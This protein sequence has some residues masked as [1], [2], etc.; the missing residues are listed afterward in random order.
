[1][2]DPGRAAWGDWQDSSWQDPSWS[3]SWSSPWGWNWG[4]SSGWA[5]DGWRGR[6]EPTWSTWGWTSEEPRWSN[7]DWQASQE[8]SWSTRD[9]QRP[10]EAS[11]STWDWK[12][13]PAE[14]PKS[15]WDWNAETEDPVR[16][17]RREQAEEPVPE[18][19]PAPLPAPSPATAYREEPEVYDMR[20]SASRELE[21]QPDVQG[22]EVGEAVQDPWLHY[23]EEK[24]TP[25]ARPPEVR[26]AP[27]PAP[28]RQIPRRPRDLSAKIF[29]SG[30][31]LDTLPQTLG[32]YCQTVGEVRYA[33]VYMDP[34]NGS[35]NGT[36][37]VDFDCE[38]T[39]RRA[40]RDL[41][42]TTLDGCQITVRSLADVP[43]HF[44]QR[45][46]TAG[47]AVFVGNLAPELTRE[48]LQAFA[49]QVGEVVFARVFIDRQ[50]G[51]SRGCGKVEFSSAEQ[52]L[53][54][55]HQLN[56][57]TLGGCAVSVEPMATDRQPSAPNVQ[58]TVFVGGLSAEMDE[59]SLLELAAPIGAVAFARVFRDQSGRSR[60]C[61]KL[62]FETDEQ[63]A[64]ALKQLAGK[65]YKGR[66]LSVEPFGQ[67]RQSEPRREPQ[68]DGRQVFVAGLTPDTTSEIL[69]DFCSITVGAV[70]SARVFTNRET[71]ES[72]GTGKVE[73]ETPELAQ[74]AVQE[75]TGR[76]L[77]GSRISAR[78]MESL[79]RVQ[80][81]EAQLRD[82]LGQA[83]EA[84]SSSLFRTPQGNL[85]GR[86]VMASAEE[87]Q[88]AVSILHDTFYV[89]KRIIVRL[90]RASAP[91]KQPQLDATLFVGGL[92]FKT[93]RE[94]LQQHFRQVGEVVH[95]SIFL[96][97]DTGQPK[98]SGKVEMASPE[99]ARAAL[100]LD[101]GELDGRPVHVKLMEAKP[102][103]RAPPGL[104]PDSSCQLF[105]SGLLPETP[106]EL[107]RDFCESCLGEKTVVYCNTFTRESKGSGKLELASAELA[108]RALKELEGANLDGATLSFRRPGTRQAPEPDGRTVFVGGLSW[109]LDSDG[110][111]D[112]AG[113]VGEVSYAAVFI[114]RETGKSKGSGKV[115]FASASSAQKAVEELSGREL[116]G[117][118]VS[119]RMM[120]AHPR[121]PG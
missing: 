107:L 36:G 29:V 119:V 1:M 79:G 72:K 30:L 75:L 97:K 103:P 43:S 56:G 110:L 84:T 51:Q 37:K 100:A 8:S 70:D 52:A 99:L 44:W 69:R 102:P 3:S 15:N 14:E 80:V 111:R 34:D 39:A 31:S 22:G 86:A 68:V 32:E 28:V 120:E 89:S 82:L 88:R 66:K 48:D 87:A 17:N 50:T 9:W 73:F 41:N 92:S 45:R 38:E 54:A 12:A 35:S 118:E 112:F 74:K 18:P 78:L 62:E 7:W 114:N 33:T 101:G 55:V 10:E 77:D 116:L 98:G 2:A 49:S 115:Q 81:S 104:R 67:E 93:T 60:N 91:A 27:V 46:D 83:G 108:D 61:G 53:E 47:C 11:W 21:K 71:G 121:K 64:E 65:D 24:D 105:V 85:A 23:K 57:K 19:L 59:G 95:A 20:G 113:Q 4:W 16:A 6:Q 58:R 42:G 5:Q 117:R 63:A 106:A 25:R 13:S 109:D 94:G 40:I 90:D 76:L 26:Q 96:D